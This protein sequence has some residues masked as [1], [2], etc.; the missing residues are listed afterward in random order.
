V[1]YF[2]IL[3]DCYGGFDEGFY[4]SKDFG[5][6]VVAVASLHRSLRDRAIGEER[7]DAEVVA[8]A[9]KCPVQ[10]EM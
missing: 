1:H 5:P 7:W 9:V 4:Q 8:T 10:F 2:A 3:F 6:V